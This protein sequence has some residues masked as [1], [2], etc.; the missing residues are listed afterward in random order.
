VK[1]RDIDW[2]ST[3]TN[4]DPAAW[5]W[6]TTKSGSRLSNLYNVSLAIG[7]DPT[8]SGLVWYDEFLDRLLT[9]A[10]KEWSDADDTG[11]AIRLQDTYNLTRVTPGQ[12]REVLTH[13]ARATPRHCVREWLQSLVWDQVPRIAEAFEDHWGCETGP[14]QPEDYLRAASANFFVGMVARVM[15]PGCKLD[16]MPVF[17]G[18]QGIFKSSALEALGG[19]WHIVSHESVTSKDFFQVLQGAW[20]VELSELDTISRAEVTRVK[21]VISTRVDRYRASYARSAVDRPRQCIFAGT[22][23]ADNWGRDET[24]LRRFWPIRCGAIN[25]T[26]LRAARD[27]LFAEAV[28]RFL[29]HKATW[30]EMP[31]ESTRQVQADRQAESILTD[32]IEPWLSSHSET[33][34][35]EVLTQ[36]LKIEPGRITRAHELEVGRVLKLAGWTKRNLRRDGKQGKRWVSP[37]LSPEQDETAE[38]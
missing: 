29:E 4:P 5:D 32:A 8:L 16:T 2:G 17:E 11:L 25:L 30:W 24:G 35:Y 22:T 10:N 3:G 31:G 28:Y 36:S 38:F 21:S 23:N 7:H 6:Q 33:T 9:G 12:V 27:Q 1:A 18:P 20:L 14:D 15:R 34:I 19:P 37:L 13:R 26:T